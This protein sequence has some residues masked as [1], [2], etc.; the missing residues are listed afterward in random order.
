MDS[1]RS[2]HYILLSFVV[3]CA[4]PCLGDGFSEP[5]THNEIHF[6]KFQTDEL[7]QEPIASPDGRLIAYMH[8]E[9]Q[10]LG[11][12]RL[13][14]MGRDG[15]DPRPLVVEPRHH[16][17]AYPKWSPD[18]EH[19]AYTSNLGGETGIWTVPIAGG[20]PQKLTERHLGKGAFSCAAAWSPDSQSLVVNASGSEK[21]QLLKYPLNGGLPDTLYQAKSIGFP[22][23]APDAERILFDGEP[24][25]NG[26]FWSLDLAAG[27]L[28]PFNSAGIKGIYPA[29]SPDGTW[30]AFQAASHIYLVPAAG[31]TP[32]QVTDESLARGAIT[33][34]W[35]YDSQALLYSAFPLEM[36]GFRAHLAIVDTTGEN[37]TILADV[38]DSGNAPWQPPSWSPDERLI[39]F[40]STGEDT[41]IAIANTEGGE[42]RHL[43]KGSGQTFSLDGM[44]IAF[45]HEEALWATNLAG[46]DPY[47]ITLALPGGINYPQWS[48]DGEWI[49]FRASQTLWKVSSYGGEPVPL[50]QDQDQA[51]PVG[52]SADSNSFYYITP[53]TE[54]A[55]Q[56]ST[57]GGIWKISTA[58]PGGEDYVTTNVGWWTD[59]SPDGTFLSAGGLGAK[60]GLRIHHLET[61]GTKILRFDKAPNHQ[62]IS[63]S[64]SPSGTRVAFYLE[65]PWF[66]RTWRADV[67]NITKR[68]VSFP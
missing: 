57:W 12:R 29:L 55:A 4:T 3:F 25:P 5:V 56:S 63:T 22:A 54:T 19:I 16:F 37:F 43:T 59:I 42:V 26:S 10:D 34:A 48:P 24:H 61:G 38:S 68:P 51:W 15:Q 32:I 45:A 46:E 11:R 23:W 44:E 50:L 41:T 53:R 20:P 1:R 36:P 58:T 49:S 30:L 28:Q 47:P 60:F 13:W 31:G 52:W 6:T 8:V 33:V 40:T 67:G 66:T 27:A 39:A 35:D 14:V 65:R 64:I 9:E 18:G 2:L 17:Q 21:D 62:V 7:H